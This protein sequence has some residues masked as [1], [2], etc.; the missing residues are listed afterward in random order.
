MAEQ[1]KRF[2]TVEDLYIEQPTEDS[3]GVLHPEAQA[4]M[5]RIDR[6]ITKPTFNSRVALTPP[7]NEREARARSYDWKKNHVRYEQENLEYL[8][9]TVI[10]NPALL[11]APEQEYFHDVAFRA[12]HGHFDTQ[13]LPVMQAWLNDPQV[14]ATARQ[15][16]DIAFDMTALGHYE[17]VKALMQDKNF[18]L[19]KYSTLDVSVVGNAM[20]HHAS[21]NSIGV[22][23]YGEQEGIMSILD[24]VLKDDDL[25]MQTNDDYQTILYECARYANVEAFREAIKH[26]DLR[27]Y[28]DD[29]GQNIAMQVASMIYFSK[30]GSKTDLSK[31]ELAG[32]QECLAECMKYSDLVEQPTRYY[33]FDDE[34]PFEEMAKE[35]KF[36]TKAELDKAHQASQTEAT[37][38]DVSS[39]QTQDG[40]AVQA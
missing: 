40:G 11:L 35:R 19:G 39:E 16:E 29:N 27:L 33:S 23:M 22:A 12:N 3:T 14:L 25:R 17:V 21:R 37:T 5:D 24:V 15:I 18:V 30:K 34:K 26:E 8:R 31:Y 28:Q 1:K 10:Q 38:Q 6:I 2:L 20:L 36:L 32:L 9:D 7:K 13:M 4:M